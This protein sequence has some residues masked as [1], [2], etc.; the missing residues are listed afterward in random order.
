V[1]ARGKTL[2]G[3]RKRTVAGVKEKGVER[4]G[5][6]GGSVGRGEESDERRVRGRA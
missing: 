6:R 1:R 5:M 4:K 2:E 3:E